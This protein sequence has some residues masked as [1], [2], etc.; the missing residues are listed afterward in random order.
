MITVG[1]IAVTFGIFIYHFMPLALVSFN[2]HLF[3]MVL[4]VI[5]IGYFFGLSI[6]SMNL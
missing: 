2:A 5:M 4:F 3:L 6:L 1:G